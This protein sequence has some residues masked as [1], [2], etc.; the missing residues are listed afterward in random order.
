MERGDGMGMSRYVREDMRLI[1][2]LYMGAGSNSVWEGMRT[3]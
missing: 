1:G 3:W 2:V